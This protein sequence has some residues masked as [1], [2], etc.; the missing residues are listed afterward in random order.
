MGC[1][2]RPPTRQPILKV[3][4][5][6]LLR[7]VSVAR[8]GGREAQLM[9]QDIRDTLHPLATSIPFPIIGEMFDIVHLTQESIAHNVNPQLAF[10]VMLFKIGDAYERA[11]QCDRA[12]QRYIFH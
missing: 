8:V 4:K 6:S 2:L 1:A 11:C 5:L 3:A 9:H 10:E 7:D 12:R